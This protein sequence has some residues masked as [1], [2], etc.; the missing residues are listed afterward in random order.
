MDDKRGQPDEPRQD[1]PEKRPS[2]GPHARKELT[3]PDATPGT[4]S[5]PDEDANDDMDAGTG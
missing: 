2:A 3:N 5:L 1:E 4:G